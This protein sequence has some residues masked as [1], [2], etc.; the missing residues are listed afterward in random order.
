MDCIDSN[1]T[2]P[3]DQGRPSSRVSSCVQTPNVSPRSTREAHRLKKPPSTKTLLVLPRRIPT[4]VP[5]STSTPTGGPTPQPPSNSLRNSLTI[6]HRHRRRGQTIRVT[7]RESL[8]TARVGVP[9]PA[10]SFPLTCRGAAVLL[11]R[12][13]I[14]QHSQDG[15]SS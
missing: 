14:A 6:R 13:G 10:G 2:S 12:S 3:I 9:L 11:A 8:I 1:S 15:A 5:T 4:R 7:A